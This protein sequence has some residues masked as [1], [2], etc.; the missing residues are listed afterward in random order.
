[1]G[2]QFV[3]YPA[4]QHMAAFALIHQHAQPHV[5]RIMSPC[6]DSLLPGFEVGLDLL[7]ECAAEAVESVHALEGFDDTGPAPNTLIVGQA[8][9]VGIPSFSDLLL[10]HDRLLSFGGCLLLD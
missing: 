5:A 4:A 8:K 1:M 9:N 3:G 7:I 2:A 10:S 6:P